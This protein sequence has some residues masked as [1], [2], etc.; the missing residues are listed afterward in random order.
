MGI[1]V[2]CFNYVKEKDVI[3]LECGHY[4][5]SRCLIKTKKI[6]DIHFCPLSLCDYNYI[7]I[8]SK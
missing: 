7:N 2:V 6:L 1:C 4:V 5:H 3:I 8:I